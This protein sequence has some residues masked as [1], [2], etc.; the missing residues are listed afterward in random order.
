LI[1]ERPPTLILQSGVT[2]A[3]V[4]GLLLASCF[5]APL[6]A[7]LGAQVLFLHWERAHTVEAGVAFL[8]V[9]AGAAL[10]RGAMTRLLPPWLRVVAFLAIAAV[11]LLALVA[12]LLRSAPDPDGLIALASDR[13][14]RLGGVAALAGLSVAACVFA[15]RTL[16]VMRLA[17]LVLMPVLL[18]AIVTFFRLL[19]STPATAVG[20]NAVPAGATADRPSGHV[21]VLLFDELSAARVY[22]G[23]EIAPQLTHLSRLGTTSRHYLNATSPGGMT[24]EAL[25]GYVAL[26]RFDDLEI[27]RDR[28]IERRRDGSRVPATLADATGLFARARAAGYRTELVGTYLPYCALL[29]GALDRCED[30]SFYNASSID[31]TFS[32][33]DAVSTNLMFL[34]RPFPV[35]Y[36]KR[37][38]FA[39]HQRRLT[40][41][42]ESLASTDFD[43]Q[44]TLR[45]VHFSLPHSPF[46]FTNGVFDPPPD[47]FAD[48]EAAYWQ[49]VLYVDRLLGRLLQRLEATGV[50]EATTIVVTSDH[51]WR[52][53][54]RRAQWPRVPLIVHRASQSTR[55]IDD[56]PAEAEAVI[57]AL[58]RPPPA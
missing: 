14:V 58:L 5:F 53:Y 30:F 55:E 7:A 19:V 3:I 51:E 6:V 54:S 17:R 41:R 46:I 2:L 9:A 31:A 20:A 29:V 36:F 40:D 52:S 25:A 13:Q 56:R 11:P 21:L 35:G 26:R 44:P 27:D 18:V 50:S 37:L 47:P 33:L 38:A 22:A 49:Q 24:L 48:D 57:A 8:A 32:P 28:L 45:F 16:A 15:N 12:T 34:P 43:P 1:D 10:L 23:S 42:L 39:E 4:D